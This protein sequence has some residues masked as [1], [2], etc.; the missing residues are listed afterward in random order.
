MTLGDTPWTVTAD[1]FTGSR[2]PQAASGP[3]ARSQA[4]SGI[5]RNRASAAANPIAHGQRVGRWSVQRRA[6]RVSRPTRPN[7]RRRRVLVVTIPSPNPSRA[8][9]RALIVD[10]H[11]ADQPGGKHREGG[12]EREPALERLLDHLREAGHDQAIVTRDGRR[13]VTS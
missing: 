11:P 1:S 3:S 10:E 2:Q 12:D 7:S 13:V 8:V 6:E 9:Q 5:A 4:R